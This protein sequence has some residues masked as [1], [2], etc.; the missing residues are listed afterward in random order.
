MQRL[1]VRA[2]GGPIRSVA[3]AGG[4][5]LCSPCAATAPVFLRRI[6]SASATDTMKPVDP[7]STRLGW[8][9]TGV[10]GKAM[11]GHL[12]AAGYKVTVYSRTMSKAEDLVS[13]GATAASTPREVGVNS[14]IVF[15]MVGYPSDVEQVLLSDT[16]VLAGLAAGGV[17]VDMTTSQPSLARR[18][19]AA[20]LAQGCFAVD[21]PVSGGDVGARNAKLSIMSG[22]DKSVVQA[23]EP[24]WSKL[25]TC[26]YLGPSGSG[27]SCKMANQVT[28]ATCMIGLVEGLLYAHKAG[29]DVGQYLEAVRGGAAGS[30]S[31]EL[32][33]ERLLKGDMEPGFMTKHFVKDL[34]IALQ[35]C[36]DMKL[37]LPGLALAQQLYVSVE[38][39]GGADLGTQALL[40]ALE[41]LNQVTLPTK[42]G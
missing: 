42:A 14:D 33:G 13:Q 3:R 4:G 29:L 41:R 18:I 25:G 21:A 30:K 9:G 37:S 6:A 32:Y 7:S 19:D 40:Q 24:L 31:M 5:V 38:A 15:S 12:L 26:R 8:I 27:Q 16:G 39:C 11:C 1:L 36:Q 20:A 35:E 10:M 34:G 17:V 2:L 22:G 23:L 28:I